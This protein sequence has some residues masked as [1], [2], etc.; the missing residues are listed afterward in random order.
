MLLTQQLVIEKRRH[1]DR[2]ALVDTTITEGM[3]SV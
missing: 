2:S 3:S 1:L